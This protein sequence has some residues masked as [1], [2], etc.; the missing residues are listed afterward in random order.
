MQRYQYPKS[1]ELFE[2]AVKVIPAGIPGHLGPASGCF[3]PVSAYPF[4]CERAEGTYFWDVDGNRFID[5]MCAYG[6]NILGYNHPE[7]DAAARAQIEKANCTTVPAPL[8][9]ELAELL[10]DTVDSADWAM[11]AKNG[12]DVTNLAMLT[13]RAATGRKKIV[14]FVGGYHGVHPWMLDVGYPGVLYEDIENIITI[15]FNNVKMFK[16][17]LADHH[18]DIAGVIS[19]PYDHQAMNENH[20]PADGFWNEVRQ[21]CTANGIVLILDD[22]RVDLVERATRRKYGKRRREGDKPRLRHAGRDAVH[23]LLGDTELIESVGEFFHEFTDLRRL[24]EVRRQG[25]NA[26]VLLCQLTQSLTIDFT[27]RKL[28]LIDARK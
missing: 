2:R 28:R 24:S 1:R 18:G 5:Y 8:M 19:T 16:R 12:G 3:I 17:V 22:V 15:P 20:L 25:D 14:K 26:R 7:V 21:L 27:C 13:A 23:V 6:P 4:F 11:F 10:V 9:I